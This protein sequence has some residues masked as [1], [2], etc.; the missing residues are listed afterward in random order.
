[1]RIRTRFNI[2]QAGVFV[3]GFA[4]GVLDTH[5]VRPAHAKDDA[6]RNAES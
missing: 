3:P 1:M 6:R 2:A 4:V 5:R